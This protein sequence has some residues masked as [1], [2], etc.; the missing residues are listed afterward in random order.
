MKIRVDRIE[1]STK[2]RAME[3]A[4]ILSRSVGATAHVVPRE[5]LKPGDSLSP[6]LQDLRGVTE[7]RM[8]V[9]HLP[10]ME[11][12]ASTLLAGSSS[13][14]KIRFGT[15]TVVCLQGGDRLPWELLWMVT[16][17]MV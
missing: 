4:E 6:V 5:G 15:A 8:L 11:Y 2:T 10:Y 3:T 12:M 17:E 1:C 9:G 16:P 13:R 14:L 7:D